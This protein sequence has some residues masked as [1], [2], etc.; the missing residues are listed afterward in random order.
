[1]ARVTA[2]SPPRAGQTAHPLDRYFLRNVTGISLVELL[3]GLGM[4]VVFDSTFLPLFLRRLGATNLLIGLAPTLASAGVALSAVLAYTLTARLRRKKAALIIVHAVTALPLLFFGLLL[5][6]TGIHPS[7]LAVFMALYAVFSLSVGLILP[8]WQNYIVKI[9]TERRTMPAMGVMMVCQSAARLAGGIY[10]VGMVER[11]S[12][13]AQ[14]AGLIF[15]LV[16]A[17]FLA[18][19]FPFIFTVEEAHPDGVEAA[20]PAH[21][22]RGSLRR[23]FSNRPYLR[24]LATEL[25]YIGLTGVIAFYANYATELCGISPALAS[26]LF[27]VLYCSG[28]VLANGLLGWAN[29][30]DV[31][32]K[33]LLTKT[34]ALG[35]VVLLA[36]HSALWVFLLLSVLVGISRGTRGMVFAPT[37]KRLSGEA[38]ATLY[39]SVA[40]ILLLPLSMG[41]PIVNGLFLDAAR[42][43]GG[44]SYRIIF[45]AM[46]CL[47]AAGLYFSARIPAG[48]PGRA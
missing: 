41:L 44:W 14:G 13:S 5:L 4:P 40:P 43:M 20:H 42:D 3:W 24:F 34:L 25:E 27:V 21:H 28:G 10:L 8:V 45:L 32:T 30:L 19:S 39:F 7:T 11:Y 26:G 18:G 22:P 9:F 15:T 33:Y 31:R 35:G 36:F 48:R 46:A 16:G 6:A 2:G 29:L 1:M 37:V 47:C 17:L 23:L 38:D 12:F